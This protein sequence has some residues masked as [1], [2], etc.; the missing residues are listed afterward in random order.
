MV[1]APKVTFGSDSVSF[2][3]KTDADCTK[4]LKT[5]N[6]VQVRAA[7]TVAADKAKSCCMY[8]E[9]VKLPSGTNKAVGDTAI[10][11]A[12]TIYGM[13][14]VTG[15]ASKYC[16]ANFPATI[17]SYGTLGTYDSKTGE[18]TASAA[19]GSQVVKTYCDGSAAALQVAAVVAAAATISMY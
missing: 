14:T 6:G 19:Y 5:T 1:T 15:E 7:I 12:K 13:P 4:E 3:C 8:Y 16:N 17:T 11:A 18:Y 10:T 2:A 9:V